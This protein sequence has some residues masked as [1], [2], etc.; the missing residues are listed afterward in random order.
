MQ[1][2]VSKYGTAAHLALLAVAPLFLYPFCA[3]EWTATALIWLSPFAALWVVV[4]PSRRSNEMLHD[5]R[6]RVIS[7]VL[8]DPLFWIL[9]VLTV[10][11][12]VRWANGGIGLAY[13]AEKDV[14]F[15]RAPGAMFLPGCVDGHGRLQFAAA[16][17]LLVV[18]T[19]CRHALGKTA[20]A[21]FLFA[22]S[23]LA[24]LAGIVAAVAFFAGHEGVVLAAKCA[25]SNPSYYGVAFGMHLLGGIVA[26]VGGFEC[27][28][29]KY[30]ALFAFAIGGTSAGLYFFAPSYVVVVFLAAALVQLVSSCGCEAFKLGGTV[31]MKCVAAVIIAS[32][33]PVLCAMGLAT[34]ELNGLRLAPFRE[35]GSFFDSAFLDM[36]ETLSGIAAKV[37]RDRP[38]LGTGL[39]SFPLDIRFNA[40]D[41]DWSIIQPSQTAALQGWWHLVAERGIVG[42][43]SLA[44]VAGMML[45]TY[46]RRLVCSIGRSAFLPGCI[47]GPVAAAALATIT[48]ADVSF[49]RPEV[50]L[51]AGAFFALSANSFPS[52]VKEAPGGAES[53]S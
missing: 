34:D 1:K 10:M 48:F 13:D 41:A 18:V 39:G 35:G 3:A 30:L 33:I 29:N 40:T 15:M 43:V 24:G 12:A 8:R 16:L 46:V 28:W 49:L 26:L 47:L 38:W 5:A 23:V 27:R 4:E 21:S 11:A 53:A 20:R 9:A 37:W 44:L 7:G 50:M 36:R 22:S 51:A 17:A 25:A 19:G 32:L 42:A 14:W 52:P 6:M 31:P 45:F 2:L